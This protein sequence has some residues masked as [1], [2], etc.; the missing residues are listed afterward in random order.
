MYNNSE[1]KKLEALFR[2]DDNGEIC[3]SI[4]KKLMN[5]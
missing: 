4:K 2:V 3:N 5:Y 1:N